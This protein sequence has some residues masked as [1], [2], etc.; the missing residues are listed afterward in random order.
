MGCRVLIADDDD[1]FVEL[2]VAMLDPHRFEIVGRA[3]D[4]REAVELARRL[5]PDVVT[6]DIEMPRL[7][8]IDAT[9][10]ICK[11]PEP[12]PVV[13]VSS[14][15]FLDEAVEEAREAGAHG[16][17]TKAR[18]QDELVDVVLGACRGEPFV[19]AA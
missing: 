7:N 18:V 16:Y 19:A 11:L 10:E 13:V 8:G 2:L 1:L 9:R 17:V 4:G 15:L 14:S 6:M 12:P 3:R 5:R